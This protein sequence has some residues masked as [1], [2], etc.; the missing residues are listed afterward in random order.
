MSD[1]VDNE[2]MTLSEV[3]AYLKIA[4]KTVSRMIT[5]GEIPCTKVASQWRFMKSM[6]DD[7]LISRMNV[8]PQND[9]AKILENPEGLIPFTRLTSEELILDNVKPGTKKD[10]LSQL[11]QPLVQQEIIEDAEDFLR[12]LL[13]REKMVTTGIGRG[14][15]IPHLRHPKENPGGG[16]RMV[17]GICKPGTDYESMDGRMTHLFFLLVSDSEVVHLRVMAKLN[18]ILREGDFVARLTNAKKTEVLP[19]LIEG[20]KLFNKA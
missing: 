2:I 12:K 1:S 7:W 16:P 18:Q 14:V 15:A 17:V 13:T 3:A 9:L 8:V 5:R 4:E 11:I 20:E 19:I 6:I 10:I